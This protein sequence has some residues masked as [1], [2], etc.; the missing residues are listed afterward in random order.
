ML[1]RSAGMAAAGVGGERGRDLL[2]E[3]RASFYRK[4]FLAF[5]AV[6]VIP[7]LTLAFV[8]RAYMMDRLRADIEEAAIRTT[9]V[10]QRF[11]EDSSRIQ[12]RGEGAAITLNDDAVVGIS[13]VIDQDVNVFDGARLVATSERDLFASG[14]LPTRTTADVYRAIVLDRR[15]T[16]VGEE[17]VGSLSVH[18][19]RRAAED[20]R[21]QGAAHRAADAAAARH[22]PRDRRTEPPDPARRS[23]VHPHRLRAGL[24]DG[25]ADRRPR[26]PAAARHR[27]T[28]A[29]RSRRAGGRDLVG[30][31][32]SPRR[33]LQQHGRRTAAPA[34][35]PRAHAPP[36]GLGR[37]GPP[38][39]ARNQE[40]AHADAAVGRASAPR[41]RRPRQAAL[42]G[43]RGVRRLDPRAGAPAPADRRRSSRA[44]RPRRRR[45]RCRRAPPTWSPRSS[46][47]IGRACR[48]A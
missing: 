14:L 42:S 45:G 1:L 24:L 27:A 37:H 5:V 12:E 29:R 18:G 44:S 20:R 7:V 17:R 34:G 39:R 48:T 28:C 38:G 36:R 6:A 31:V 3:V 25:R 35:R 46:S 19:G 40:S 2:H 33:G 10:A 47:P 23:G 41:P 13:R 4:L 26:E 15:A 32:A 30:R 21:R 8:A 16:F 43:A 11:V 22:R 9:T